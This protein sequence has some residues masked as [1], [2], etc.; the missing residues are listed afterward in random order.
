VAE[1][2]HEGPSF[3]PGTLPRE[4][5]EIL[6][7]YGKSSI[8]DVVDR[9]D[10]KLGSGVPYS[11]VA[12][13]LKRLCEAG[14]ATRS[15]LQ[16]TREHLYSALVSREQMERASTVDAVETVFAKSRSRREALS[17]LIGVVSQA[18]PQHVDDFRN[19]VEQRRREAKAKREP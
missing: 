11:T 4:T 15:R 18:G 5:L 16:G 3:P 1:R 2:R 10:G 17:Y 13:V 8:R 6:W 9:M 12:S 19:A 7:D 14:F